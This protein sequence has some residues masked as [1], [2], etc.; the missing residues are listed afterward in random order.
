MCI[1]EEINSFIGRSRTNEFEN[2]PTKM[3][4][5]VN[6]CLKEQQANTRKASLKLSGISELS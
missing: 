4:F 1:T 5:Y 6:G 3:R 2:V